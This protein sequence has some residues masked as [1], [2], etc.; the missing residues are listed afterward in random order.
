MTEIIR[1]LRG[2]GEGKIYKIIEMIRAV[3]NKNGKMIYKK[4]KV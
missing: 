4:A 1:Q 2:E 3:K